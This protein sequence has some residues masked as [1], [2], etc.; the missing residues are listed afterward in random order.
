[1]RHLLSHGDQ[2]IFSWT[3]QIMFVS[4][5][6][7]VKVVR[8]EGALLPLLM[9]PVAWWQTGVKTSVCWQHPAELWVY[10]ETR[11][12]QINLQH[13][14]LL[15]S[16]QYHTH[17]HTPTCSSAILL[18]I[19]FFLLFFPPNSSIA[20]HPS[21]SHPPQVVCSVTVKHCMNQWLLLTPTGKG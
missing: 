12:T 4:F 1:M 21:S 20:L 16:H 10:E 19:L 15:R 5:F 13:P 9:P 18:L 2:N 8:P 14:S 11:Q 3:K 17:A 6:G 7:F